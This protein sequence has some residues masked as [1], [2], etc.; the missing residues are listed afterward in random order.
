MNSFKLV[1]NRITA[2]GTPVDDD[3]GGDDPDAAACPE[4]TAEQIEETDQPDSLP[5]PPLVEPEEDVVLAPTDTSADQEVCPPTEGLL[6]TSRV[7]M[8]ILFFPNYMIIQPILL[9]Y[10]FVAIPSWLSLG[11]TMAPE[12]VVEEPTTSAPAQTSD[13]SPSLTPLRPRSSLVALDES[14]DI[15]EPA[16]SYVDPVKLL[17]CTQKYII[18]PPMRLYPLS[19]KPELPKPRKKL[20]LDLDETLI[21]SLLRTQPRLA[22]SGAPLPKVIEIQLNGLASLYYVYKRP[23]CDYFLLEISKW[24]ELQIFTASVREYADPIIDWLEST[25]RAKRRNLQD[26]PI[27]TKRY[28]R[29]HCTLR[30]GVGYV[31][32]LSKFFASDEL[33]SVVILDNSPVLYALHENN[34]VMIEGWINDQHDR[35]LI[36]LLPMLRLLSRCIDVRYILGL[37]SGDKMFGQANPIRRA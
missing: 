13:R 22:F 31:K 28:Y 27:F 3:G 11:K 14:V 23:H 20:V 24:Y 2:Y 7:I 33:K 37:R 10:H 15:N 19:R 30:K 32:D 16:E 18:P 34:A 12:V 29:D 6:W 1:A 35:D 4:T 21:H 36:N 25:I 5:N 9:I 26:T 8:A 17:L